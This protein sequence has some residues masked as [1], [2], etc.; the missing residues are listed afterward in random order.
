M[1]ENRRKAED[2]LKTYGGVRE[3]A[4]NGRVI[5]GA[6][7]AAGKKAGKKSGKKAG[8]RSVRMPGASTVRNPG[9][10]LRILPGGIFKRITS[11]DSMGQP[12]VCLFHGK[13][14]VPQG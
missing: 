4:A 8:K 3:H 11:G 5:G 7:S 13:M 1:T 14:G 12:G 6:D 2:K 10:R 9:M